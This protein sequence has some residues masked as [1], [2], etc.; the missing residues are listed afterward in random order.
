MLK[1]IKKMFTNTKLDLDND[2]KIESY[3]EEIKGVF[4]Q[5]TSMSN[6]LDNVNAKLQ[7]IIEDEKSAQE[8]E[9]D[10]LERII[11][12]AEQK[13][14]ESENRINTAHEE[15]KANEKLQEKVKEFI[16]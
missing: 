8:C 10:N 7:E 5:F 4:A 9:R 2:G 12:E 14:A 11:K 15:I 13:I 1:A 6:R 16:I 3:R